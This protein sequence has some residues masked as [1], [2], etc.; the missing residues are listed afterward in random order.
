MEIARLSKFIAVACQAPDSV[1]HF[2]QN[3]KL[4]LT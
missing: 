1:L 4:T 2:T 3:R